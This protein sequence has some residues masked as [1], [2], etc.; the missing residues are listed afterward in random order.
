MKFSLL[1]SRSI[2]QL[3]P[4]LPCANRLANPGF[5]I[6]STAWSVNGTSEA[7]EHAQLGI[8][9]DCGHQ[10]L[11]SLGANGNSQ[12]FNCTPEPS[13]H[14]VRPKNT[15][16]QPGRCHL[17]PPKRKREDRRR[18]AS[19]MNCVAQN[20]SVSLERTCNPCQSMRRIDWIPE[21]LGF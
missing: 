21:V 3:F 18:Y 7:A 15:P 17:A 16:P 20:P 11:R 14:T 6:G 13:G 10:I 19:A 4:M 8:I 12:R 5:G 1:H 9:N 2:S